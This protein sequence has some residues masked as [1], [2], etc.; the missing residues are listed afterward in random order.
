[1]LIE[2]IKELELYHTT[3]TVV[4]FGSNLPFPAHLSQPVISYLSYCFF[5][6]CWTHIVLYCVDL[7]FSLRQLTG[8]EVDPKRRQEKSVAFLQAYYT[9]KK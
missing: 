4:F 2:S 9:V 5:S 1:M 6:L 8:E 7:P 3:N